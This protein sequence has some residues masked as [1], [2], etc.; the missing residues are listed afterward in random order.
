MDRY[1]R[2][3]LLNDPVHGLVLRGLDRIVLIEVAK[4]EKLA[5]ML[6]ARIDDETIAVNGSERG[7]LKPALLKLGWPAADLAG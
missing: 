1:G 4:S 7:R 2:L 3:Q 6:G 5:G